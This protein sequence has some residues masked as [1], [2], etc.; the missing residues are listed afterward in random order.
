MTK[1]PHYEGDPTL[2]R[3]MVRPQW[4]LALLLSLAVAAGFAWLAQWQM[5]SAIKL[6]DTSVDTENVYPIHE[7]TSVGTPVSDQSAGRMVEA[8]LMLIP[9]DSYIVGARMNQG[10]EGYW[11]VSH[12]TNADQ[13][14][15][16]AVALGWAPTYAQ[17]Q[18]AL[19]VIDADGA[20]SSI[21]TVTGRYTFAEGTV[22]PDPG[23]PIDEYTSM[24][25]GQAINLWSHWDGKA[26]AGYIVSAHAPAGLDVIDSFAPLPEEKINWLNLFYAVEWIVFAGFAVFFW[27]RL[28]RDA[29]EKEHE[30][31]ALLAE[32]S[33]EASVE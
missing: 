17:A 8:D 1:R 11:V 10:E 12:F 14:E 9:G 23:Q 27:Y 24:S 16:I 26:F 15:H 13:D 19:N 7:I 4:I 18:T 33:G 29:W 5:G 20:L 28:T 3:V 31:Q 21:H 25:T 30:M 2:V 6:E 22:A 32:S